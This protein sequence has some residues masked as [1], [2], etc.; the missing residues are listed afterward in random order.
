M[1][2]YGFGREL[3]GSG[4]D[5]A[6]AWP[7]AFTPTSANTAIPATITPQCVNLTRLAFSM[8][9]LL[10]TLN[11]SPSEADFCFTLHHR[12]TNLPHI[13]V[14]SSGSATGTKDSTK[15]SKLGK[16][17]EIDRVYQLRAAVGG[18]NL[19]LRLVPGRGGETPPGM[20]GQ[21]V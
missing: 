17:G 13:S 11:S 2:R 14:K 10:K 1:V 5:C 18:A 4:A 9:T 20:W 8:K 15:P 6:L 21:R 12:G 7:R 3:T 19:P 16:F